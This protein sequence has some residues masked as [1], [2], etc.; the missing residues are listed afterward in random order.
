[1]S[2]TSHDA[3]NVGITSSSVTAAA[4][5]ASGAIGWIND[6][7]IVIGLSLSIVSLAIGMVFKILAIRRSERQHQ[8]RM[9]AEALQNEQALE[10]MRT[11]IRQNLAA[12]TSSK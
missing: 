1:M 6:Y 4:T 12:K 9:E 8:E 2:G 7:A 3:G 11:E 10:V 5:T